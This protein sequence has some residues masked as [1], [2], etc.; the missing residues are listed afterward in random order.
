L[1]GDAAGGPGGER[2]LICAALI[3]AVA[4]R[5]Y[6]LTSVSH[7]IERAGVDQEVFDRHFASLED[8]FSSAWDTV[9]AEL[10]ERMTAAFNGSGEWQD[11]LRGALG[12]GLDY[13]AA[14]ERRAKVYVAEAVYVS[15]ELR[16][17]Q[18]DALVR[19]SEMVD[20]GRDGAPG[21]TRKLAGIAE[22]VAGAIWHRVQQLVQAGRSGELRQEVPRLMYVAVLPYRGA[23]A[24]EAELT[25]S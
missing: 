5:G 23:E 7:V 19:L 24:A 10:R 13:L 22:A 25:R 9:D 6:G 8:C 20:R 17:R 1:A 18:R 15:E 14:D 4:S 3:E 12:A 16:D 2:E 11:G 21:S